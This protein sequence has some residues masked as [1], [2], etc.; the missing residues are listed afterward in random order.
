MD[1]FCTDHSAL[2]VRS[3]TE[4]GREPDIAGDARR[5]NKRLTHRSNE[6]PETERQ[7]SY[8][9]LLAAI[10]FDSGRV[11]AAFEC[12]DQNKECSSAVAQRF[13]SASKSQN[14]VGCFVRRLRLMIASLT[15]VQSMTSVVRQY[16]LY[17]GSSIIPFW[18]PT[19]MIS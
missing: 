12:I 1:F 10:V 17:I 14:I 13:A 11:S 7:R 18:M 2:D 8:A 15:R 9:W 16:C 5:A 4:S 6:V 3:T 19:A